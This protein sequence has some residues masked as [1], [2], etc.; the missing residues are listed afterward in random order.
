MLKC[1]IDSHR[2]YS[3]LV[4]RRF[5][6]SIAIPFVLKIMDECAICFHLCLCYVCL[7]EQGSGDFEQ[8]SIEWEVSE[9]Q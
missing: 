4:R 6:S 1:N 3:D 2:S 9:G 8:A 5:A 7:R